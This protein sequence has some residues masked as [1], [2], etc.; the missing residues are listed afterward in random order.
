MSRLIFIIAILIF[1]TC[2]QNERPVETSTESQSNPTDSLVDNSTTLPNPVV[3][4]ITCIEALINAARDNDLATARKLL[5][6]G[7]DVNG[8]IS[9]HIESFVSPLRYGIHHE[10]SEMAKLLLSY[11]AAPCQDL[12]QEKSPLEYALNSSP[13][14]TFELLAS[15]CKNVN[16]LH[17]STNFPTPLTWAIKKGKINRVNVLLKRGLSLNSDSL[18]S[19][20]TPLAV[21]CSYNQFDIFKLFLENGAD[22][23]AQFS[24]EGEDCIK[25]LNEISV[26]HQLVSMN[27]YTDK[28]IVMKF[29]EE[30]MKYNPNMNI[31]NSQGFTAL[32]FACFDSDVN[33][34][35]WL[36]NNGAKLET[37]GYSAI[38]CAA[39]FSNYKMVEVLLKIG[40]DPN[41]KTKDGRSPF[42]VSYN[43]CGDGFGEG[44]TDSNR[45]KT[46]QLLLEYGSD[47]SDI[48]TACESDFHRSFCDSTQFKKLLLKY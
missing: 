6:D 47:K 26:L 10:D 19:S 42:Q 4:P 20:L 40:A 46:A 12:G 22:V 24:E 3:K 39:M 32:D 31:E 34:V 36:F 2:S 8:T 33:L 29:L 9:N 13:F 30:L 21:A 17:S 7:C 5:D 38:H 45:I 44:I 15:K 41:S 1:C 14:K 23:N 43:C 48:I 37:E 28:N 25:C 18:I 27:D 16:I 11:G 35:R